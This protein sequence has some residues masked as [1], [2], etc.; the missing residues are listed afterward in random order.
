M[1]HDIGHMVG[2]PSP[3]KGQVEYPHPTPRNIRPVCTPYPLDI[4]PWDPPPVTS[5]VAH[6]EP[7]QTCSF[8]GLPRVKSGCGP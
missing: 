2:Y 4:R 8:G 7:V 3:G 6:L 1:H 5:A